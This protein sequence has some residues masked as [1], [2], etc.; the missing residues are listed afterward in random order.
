VN[1][2]STG[3]TLRDCAMPRM[4]G[5]CGA[6]SSSSSPGSHTA[7]SAHHRAWVAPEAICTLAPGMRLTA[8]TFAASR[9]TSG[10][11]PAAGP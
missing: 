9:S 10:C 2:T 4:S 11:Q 1:G 6:S 8:V 3:V 5:Q 7:P